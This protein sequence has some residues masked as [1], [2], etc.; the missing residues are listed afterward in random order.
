MST[1]LSMIS[2][3]WEPSTTVESHTQS[4]HSPSAKPSI[5]GIVTFSGGGLPSGS[6]QTKSCPSSS[7]VVQPRVRARGG[8]RRAYGISWHLPSPPQ[9]Q[10]WNG[11]ATLSPTT[12]PC[13]RS[14]PMCRQ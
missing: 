1:M 11:Q 12:S 10:E 3:Q 4:V 7:M 5:A 2:R 8:T 13:E 6:C 9:R 14:P